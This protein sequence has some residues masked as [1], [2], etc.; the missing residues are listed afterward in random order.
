MKFILAIAL[1]F[2]VQ[3]SFAQK[4]DISSLEKILYAPISSVDSILKKSM[5]LLSE[6]QKDKRYCNYYYTS[7]ERKELFKHLLRSLSF[8]DIYEEKDTSRIILYRTYYESDQEELKKQLLANGYELTSQ[9]NND[10]V[11]KKGDLTITNKISIKTVPRGKP[12]TAY[13]Y[14]LGR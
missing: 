4:L 11:Y 8:M 9:T 6:K 5:F 3:F 12:M 13:E 14:E 2:C 1:C 7:Y 10:F